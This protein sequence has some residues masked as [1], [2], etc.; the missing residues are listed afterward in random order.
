M[1]MHAETKMIC[2]WKSEWASFREQHECWLE[3]YAP[4]A[5]VLYRLP[6]AITTTLVRPLEHGRPILSDADCSAERA[7]D[8][9]CSKFNAEGVYRNQHVPYSYLKPPVPALSLEEF[10]SNGFAAEHY[11][12]IQA[13]FK[14]LNELSARLKGYIGRLLADPTFRASAQELRRAWQDLPDA[15]RPGL[16]VRRAME[17][18]WS[19]DA[20][21]AGRALTDFQGCFEAFLDRYGLL[22][23]ATW[24]LPDPAGPLLDGLP[25]APHLLAGRSVLLAL[26]AHFHVQGA[27]DLT[28]MVRKLQH[29]QIQHAGL[30]PSC[31]GPRAAES[32]GRMLEIDHFSRVAGSRYGQSPRPKGFVARL[33]E[34]LADCLGIGLEH[35]RTLHR[36]LA[37]FLRGKPHTGRWAC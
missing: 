23:M 31:V 12:R 28:Q 32:Y 35:F 29:Q 14:H 8:A 17:A 10:C 7:F 19:E 22:G 13:G 18:P 4:G 16:P 5:D 30:D 24:D 3:R 1:E 15:E 6:D 36:A 11:P 37:R 21:S 20:K 2:D 9:L 27:D 34:A 33:H 26:P 25:K